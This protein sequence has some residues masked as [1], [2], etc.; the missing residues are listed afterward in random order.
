MTLATFDTKRSTRKWIIE[1]QLATL[2]SMQFPNSSQ[3]K[4][5]KGEE[6]AAIVTFGTSCLHC[7]QSSY[8]SDFARSFSDYEW[9][10]RSFV[11]HEISI[12]NTTRFQYNFSSIDFFV[13]IKLS[14]ITDDQL[15]P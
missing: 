11:T 12:V 13:I 2:Q 3:A 14:M 4:Q 15:K 6:E 8:S 1:E 10:R 9:L 5:L 7:L